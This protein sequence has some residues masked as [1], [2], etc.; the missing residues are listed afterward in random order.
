M[1]IEQTCLSH[2]SSNA[3]VRVWINGVL[4]KEKTATLQQK[5]DSSY[6]MDLVRTNGTFTVQ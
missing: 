4:K 2:D 5:G 6:V 1:F 3:T